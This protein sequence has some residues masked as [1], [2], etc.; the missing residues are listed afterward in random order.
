MQLF[1]QRLEYIFVNGK[2]WFKV[3]RIK[4]TIELNVTYLAYFAEA[5]ASCFW[6]HVI[7][8]LTTT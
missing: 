5:V 3:I 1:L 8:Y 6:E 7:N 4:E 2:F